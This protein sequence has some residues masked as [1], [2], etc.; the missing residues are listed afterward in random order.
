VTISIIEKLKTSWAMSKVIDQIKTL[1]LA[2]QQPTLNAI[3]KQFD[4]QVSEVSFNNN[5]SSG[6]G[7][8]FTHTGPKNLAEQARIIRDAERRNVTW[9]FSGL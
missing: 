8:A 9:P 7:T 1:P 6:R 3:I 4:K 2:Q 5:A